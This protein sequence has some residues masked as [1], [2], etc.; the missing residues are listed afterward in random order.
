MLPPPHAIV[1]EATD[2]SSLA[3]SDRPIM[4][5]PEVCSAAGLRAVHALF[6]FTGWAP[7]MMLPLDSI[8]RTRWC[9]NSMHTHRWPTDQMSLL[10][11]F[12]VLIQHPMGPHLPQWPPPNVASSTWSLVTFT[13]FCI[14]SIAASPSCSTLFV[15]ASAEF[16]KRSLL[17]LTRALYRHTRAVWLRCT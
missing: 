6:R 16:F 9:T 5:G 15:A 10:R 11:I 13:A 12:E 14:L 2:S 3:D 1:G 4:H 17:S 8:D 7:P